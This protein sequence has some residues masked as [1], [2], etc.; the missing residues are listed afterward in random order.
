MPAVF[1]YCELD[2]QKLEVRLPNEKLEQLKLTIAQWLHRKSA[3]KRELLSLIGQLIHATKVVIPGR[4]FLRH[5]ITLS[6]VRPNLDD[7][8]RLNVE[9]RSDLM[10]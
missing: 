1:R 2:T 4:V 3:S 7:R 9:F 8:V 10:W 6:T 5:M